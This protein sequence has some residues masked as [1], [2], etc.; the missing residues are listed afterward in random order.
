MS[1]KCNNK[2]KYY[3][4]NHLNNNKNNKYYYKNKKYSNQKNNVKVNVFANDEIAINDY[5][6]SIVD[7]FKQIV[8][9]NDSSLSNNELNT[10][11]QNELS[12]KGN[13]LENTQSISLTKEE[14]ENLDDFIQKNYKNEE[15]SFD[16]EPMLIKK[17]QDNIKENSVEE[18]KV[19]ENNT[20][21][22]IKQNIENSSIEKGNTIIEEKDDFEDLKP[23]EH[24]K[25]NISWFKYA[26]G[27]LLLIL[28]LTGV[29]YAYFNYT[30]E[31][32]RQADIVAGEVYVRLQNS[33]APTLTLS[34]A[35]PRTDTEAR[36]R[37]DNYVDFTILGKNTSE[38]KEVGY[39]FNV[40]ATNSDN[41]KILIDSQYL[42]FDLS[43][44]DGS[45]NETALLSGVTLTELNNKKI[46]K[47]KVPVNTTSQISKKYRIRMWIS[48][49]VVISDTETGATY[50]QE[51]FNK[52]YANISINISTET[53][54]ETY[55][56]YQLLA[57]NV[58]TPTNPI[59]FANISS[60]SNGQGLYILPGTE[61]DT[62][63]IYYYRG[64]VTNN[65][66]IFGGFCWQM[67]RTTDTGGIKMIYNGV[68]TGTSEEPT[69]ENTAHADRIISS[70]RFN[71][72]NQSVADVGYMYNTRYTY[73]TT[74]PTS[75]AYFG[76]SVEYGEYDPN[77]PGTNVYRLVD[78]GNGSVGT[79]LDANHHYSCNVTTSTGTCVTIRYY[80]Y[81]EGTTYRYINLTGGEDIEDALYKMTG[82]GTAVVK[83]RPINQNYVLN[84]NDSTI[85]ATIES[86]FRTNLTNEVD[87]AKRNYKTYLEDTIY[88]NDRSLK[89]TG[90][91]DKY[92]Q[93]GWNPNGGSLSTTLYFGT[94]NRVDNSWYSTTNVPSMTC[95]NETDRFSISSSVAHLNYPVGLLTA[96]EIVMA[97][98][99]GN[100]YTDNQTYYLYTGNHYWSLSS[101]VVGSYA[102]GAFRVRDNGYLSY[103]GVTESYGV[104]PVVSLK[105][106]TEF[107]NGGE[108]TPTKPYVV[109]YE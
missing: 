32:T 41:T 21:K 63:P 57:K 9:N 86:W 74:S 85:K 67:V 91:S 12:K 72:Q 100:S 76:T 29:T 109:K 6:D 69:C 31:D 33:P 80:Y 28:I 96:D 4:N 23:K 79:T 58:M 68:V 64:A 15:E 62:N 50:T 107:E 60:S 98:A 7:S 71:S 70:S 2:K 37:T 18:I 81:V 89:T 1:N 61:N 56:S 54:D 77:N 26:L 36:E 27:P 51:Q 17:K 25:L 53:R 35:Y 97:G 90:S 73:Q 19:E 108:G 101:Y 39:S 92:E 75:G 78:D 59:N 11:I 104:R 102:V 3:S 8:S 16:D 47:L 105:L 106:G 46:N 5:N 99:A 55:T 95:P 10:F 52:L 45:N 83:S 43:E 20:F 22:E 88:C 14:Y 87:N 84:Q 24:N 65:N 42:K 30:K 49:Q 38:T 48:D 13:N 34:K 40:T 94:N 82:N 103:N 44:L 93:S 66:V